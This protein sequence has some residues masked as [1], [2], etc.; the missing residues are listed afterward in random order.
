M[1]NRDKKITKKQLT[2]LRT[3]GNKVFGQCRCKNGSLC[4]FHD[5]LATNFG[6]IISTR[7]LSSSD[8]SQAIA[9]LAHTT[10]YKYKNKYFNRHK[11]YGAGQRRTRFDSAQ[12]EDSTDAR[13]ASRITQSE[14]SKIAALEIVLGWDEKRTR[15][16][17][18][19]QLSKHAAVAMLT[20]HD[21][22]SVVIGM[23]RV[24]ANG[25]DDLYRFLNTLK[26]EDLK[27]RAVLDTLSQIKTEIGGRA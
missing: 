4:D 24:A 1:N 10:G 12:R 19:R 11:Y 25:N 17:I 9:L 27:E 14:A 22:N 3:A 21:A 8:A 15:G 6:G 26:S 5:W 7:D 23:Q 18:F 13:R 2:A 16:F 20:A